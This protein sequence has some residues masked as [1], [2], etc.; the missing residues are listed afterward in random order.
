[1]LIP[2]RRHALQLYKLS[3]P[4]PCL[5]H[6]P[7]GNN[8]SLCAENPIIDPPTYLGLGSSWKCN[9]RVNLKGQDIG[10]GR[11]EIKKKKKR[12]SE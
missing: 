9:F 3:S 8:D 6:E 7:P 1:M 4:I 11:G 10:K 12:I 2:L 5:K